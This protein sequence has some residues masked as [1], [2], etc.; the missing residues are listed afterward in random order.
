MPGGH[1]A[2]A[3]RFGP[4]S[5]I[6][7]PKPQARAR[8]SGRVRIRLGHRF[9]LGLGLGSGLRSTLGLRLG[10]GSWI[11]LEGGGSRPTYQSQNGIEW[12][13]ARHFTVVR[14]LYASIHC[15]R[16]PDPNHPCNVNYVAPFEG[17]TRI[18]PFCLKLLGHSQMVRLQ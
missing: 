12:H 16:Q 1:P 11:G 9:R 14:V 15:D 6:E 10:L 7:R 2:P 17:I 5:R 3:L 4:S 18:V 8:L 13:S